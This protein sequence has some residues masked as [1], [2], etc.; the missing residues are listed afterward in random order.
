MNLE[1][2][3]IIVNKSA[4]ELVQMLKNPEDY[5]SLMPETLQ[6]F[7]ARGDGFKFGL[8]GMPEI[9]LKIDEVSEKQV[10]LKSASSSLDFSLTGVMNPINENQTEVQLLFEGKFNPFIKMMVEK[11]LNNFLGTL[12][13][14]LEKL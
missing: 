13:D 9:A 1:G 12:T 14:N 3:K 10:V 11:P 8:K 4:A 6:N 2:R 7:E 5:R